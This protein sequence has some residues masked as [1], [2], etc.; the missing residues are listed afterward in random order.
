MKALKL[1]LRIILYGTG[2]IIV[3]LL[4]LGALTQ[5][6]FFR[7]RLR[8]F[9]L[10][11]LDSLLVAD[12][13]M[14]EIQ[15]NLVTGFVVDGF[16][17]TL[18]GDTLLGAAQVGLR[19][20][21]SDIPG[22][23]ISFHNIVLERPTI[24]LLRSRS[25]VW[26]IE[27]MVTPTP[28]DSTTSH[29]DWA[30]H[31]R[32]LEIRDGTVMVVDSM[33]MDE[34]VDLDRPR[35]SLYYDDLVLSGF[36]LGLSFSM[37]RE[38]YDVSITRLEFSVD[39]SPVHVRQMSGDVHVTPNDFRVSEF[40]ILTDSSHVMLGAAMDHVDLFDGISLEALQ[41]C[42]TSVELSVNPINFGEL[43]RVLP[44][45]QI[46][47]GNL[48][49]RI[50]AHGP[51]GALPV[52][53]LDLRFGESRIL[54]NGTLFNLHDPRNLR[55]DVH[56]RESR[57]AP[58]DPLALMPSF[59]LPDFSSLGPVEL[60]VHY[61]GTPLEFT[62]KAVLK[63]QG[64][65]LRTDD[66]A[67]QIGGP[68][69]LRYHGIVTIEGL[70]IARV[71]DQEG[72]ATDLNGRITVDGSGT[73]LAKVHGTLHAQ[74]DSSTFRGLAV[75]NAD[76]QIRAWDRKVNAVLDMGLST[77]EYHLTAGLDETAE[78]EP[79]F[80]VEGNAIGVNLAELSGQEQRSSDLNL[81]VRIA[82]S[83]LT[84]ETLGGD[85]LVSLNNSRY[86][87]Y[88]IEDGDFHLTL[89]QRDTLHKQVTL[90]SPVINA[91][92]EGGF[93]ISHLGRLIEFQVQNAGLTINENF[94]RF[95]TLFQV[96]V[97]TVALTRLR[98]VLE[99]EDRRVTCT[100]GVQVKDLHLVS[101]LV[102]GRM[103]NGAATLDGSL[104][105]GIR[106]LTASTHLAV[107]EFYYGDVV[108]GVLIEGGDVSIGAVD[109]TPDQFSPKADLHVHAAARM[110]N[111]SSTELDSMEVD[112]RIKDQRARYLIG[113]TMNRDAHLMLQGTARLREDSITC[114]L[115]QVIASYRTMTWEADPGARVV[116]HRQGVA[117]DD[118]VLRRN[119]AQIAVAGSVGPAGAL[120]ATVR[121]T[122]VSLND[123]A[124]VLENTEQ[125][126]E[127]PA[128]EGTL[129]AGITI[130]GTLEQPAMN[131]VFS[132]D[133]I[134][135]RQIPFGRV[136]GTV[137]FARG[138]LDLQVAADVTNGRVA[139]GP[140]LTADG[141]IPLF[142]DSASPE[143]HAR[144]FQFTI[145]S[146]GT[147]IT[148]LDPL[149][150]NFNDLAGMLECDLSISGTAEHPRYAGQLQLSDCQFLF[151]PNNM[152]YRVEG[153]FRGAGD[154]IMVA[155][156]TVRNDP[157][158][159]R[160]ERTGLV[161]LGGDFALRNFTPGDFNVSATGQ[162]HVVKEA[163]RKSSLSIYG[164]LFVEIGP[165]E[166]RF[167][168]NIDRSLLRGALIIRNSNLIFPPT[169]Q[170]VVEESALS[171]PIIVY[172]D[173][174][175][176]GEKAVLSAADRYFGTVQTGAG[177]H[178]TEN[179]QGAVSFL[180]GLRYDL[181]IETTGGTTGIRM[182]FNPI[183]S[184]ELV[185]TIDGRFSITEDGRRWL[186]DLTVSR[187]YYN[188]YRRFDASGRIQ[189]TGDFMN[190]ELD[191]TATYRG[192]RAVHDTATSQK[193]ESIVVTVDITGPRSTATL[194]MSM[195][196]DGVDYYAYNGLKSNDVQSD[197]L[198]FIIYGS[199]P[200]TVAEKGEVTAELGD[201][202][203]RSIL[204]GASSLLTGT[205][206]EFLRSQ[207][208]FI[209]SVELNFNTQA[210]D[211]ES[212]DIRLSGQAWSGYWRYGGQI[213]DDPL[214]NA[215]FSVLY[216][217]GS[218]FNK[219]SL[220]NFMMELESKVER[221]TFGQPNDLRRTNSARLFYRFSF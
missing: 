43:A 156:A 144:E 147:P 3:L 14:G 31:L 36:S 25:G 104:Q 126:S 160:G 166:L 150:P 82:G 21:L 6:Q 80:T 46:L 60:D 188:F 59:D 127:E 125:T 81:D 170:V 17:I 165:G 148:I 71:L 178:T 221:G 41:A 75:R 154:R 106:R 65:N 100:F 153:T 117:V 50:R 90:T 151:E 55:M 130:A 73:N 191:I 44:P 28:P 10:A 39:N 77:G 194:A 34:A 108:S 35:E 79:T 200:L 58:E 15:G 132:A 182:I 93:D 107:Q 29:F 16:A 97:D 216:S 210:G 45:I 23:T 91:S 92:I 83:G 86:G 162:L 66:F 190:P 84:L 123:V 175:K 52:D 32:R 119:A 181:D 167:T 89:D 155:E 157:S 141:S 204:T 213:L 40:R 198:G 140:E 98:K 74:V 120:A 4:V 185:A 122:D 48:T 38:V 8:A 37:D 218:I 19:Y 196:I 30:V 13:S 9:A 70:N 152:Y 12:V 136:H 88:I 72:W 197:A 26:N 24:R 116:F 215:N 128:F 189:F 201:T 56:M 54:M 1:I 101:L 47:S 20:N 163:T 176:Y 134:V 208:G 177:S 69:T 205:L 129:G 161:R 67:L 133:D 113:G 184:E 207:T 195:T 121:G 173:T 124:S 118:F 95:D 102:G 27:R 138:V 68:R 135:L 62:T 164:D 76:V 143:D 94:A 145:R 99:K 18:D 199:F 22:K 115:D 109:L 193:D 180:E 33:S 61:R 2:G 87:T 203:R 111:V 206:S 7:D 202:F 49:G 53:E 42:P 139:D 5:T 114:V 105:G 131:A 219:P 85:F 212:A 96:Q 57:I 112:V 214:G 11:E 169:D 172:D 137:G 187:A 78:P 158:D 149:L 64:G 183:S 168:G 171:V 63:T 146:A 192:T 51:F 142:R 217:F 179:L 211:K 186:G 174:S 103:F 220:R 209:S 159:E 110:L